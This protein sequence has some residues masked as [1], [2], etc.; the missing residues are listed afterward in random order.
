[1]LPDAGRRPGRRG[2]VRVLR[3]GLGGRAAGAL[4]AGLG[5][6]AVDLRVDP[7]VVERPGQDRHDDGGR[8]GAAADGAVVVATLPG[9]DGADN[10]PDDKNYR[11]DAHW[12]SAGLAPAPFVK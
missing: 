2:Q 3:S 5:H 11:S 4:L 7:H 1:M 8:L 6:L 12:T 9:G 10:E